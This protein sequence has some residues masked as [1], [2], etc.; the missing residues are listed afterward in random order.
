M[1]KIICIEDMFIH[2]SVKKGDILLC[3]F[4]NP[5]YLIFYKNRYHYIFE[6]EYDKYFMILE[7]Y[8]ELQLNKILND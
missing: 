7:E 8:R 6:R 2:I 1:N 5:I 3:R 4:D